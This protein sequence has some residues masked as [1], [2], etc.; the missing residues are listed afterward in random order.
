MRKSRLIF[1]PNSVIA[2]MMLII[3]SEALLSCS[4]ATDHTSAIKMLEEARAL[5]RERQT[6]LKFKSDT[7]YF[8][9]TTKEPRRTK[10]YGKNIGKKVFMVSTVIPSYNIRDLTYDK[11]IVLPS[12][13]LGIDVLLKKDDTTMAAI[14]VIGNIP[15]GQKTIFL[16]FR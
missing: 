10:I 14:T 12:D 3:I 9:L 16:K 1:F 15:G 8:G 11:S 4:N 2:T 5:P 7:I 13:S 6:L